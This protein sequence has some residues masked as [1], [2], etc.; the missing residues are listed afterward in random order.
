MRR[1]RPSVGAMRGL[2][3]ASGERLT[4]I[5]WRPVSVRSSHESPQSLVATEAMNRHGRSALK[6]DGNDLINEDASGH[7]DF[8][9]VTGLLAHQSS[10]DR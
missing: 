8:D 6:G 1:C 3:V 9:R 5:G 7:A 2:A 4:S 10:S